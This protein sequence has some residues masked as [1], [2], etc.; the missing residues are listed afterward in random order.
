MQNHVHIMIDGKQV[1]VINRDGTQSH[2][3]TRDRVPNWVIDRIKAKGLIESDLI[4][5]ANGTP[6]VLVPPFT[7]GT[8]IA[9][10]LLTN[11]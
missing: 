9:H 3:T 10:A 5:E 6:R 2:N 11:P 8:A 4:T 1:S 7:I